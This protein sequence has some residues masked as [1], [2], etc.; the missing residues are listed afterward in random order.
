MELCIRDVS[1]RVLHE[2]SCKCRN[3]SD[4][5][6]ETNPRLKSLIIKIS[7]NRCRVLQKSK[8]Y[9]KFAAENA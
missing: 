8:N 6:N 9:N 3:N 1:V 4:K 5:I 2:T 7:K